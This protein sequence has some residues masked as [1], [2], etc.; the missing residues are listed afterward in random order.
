MQTI[1]ELK[2]WRVAAPDGCA[3]ANRDGGH[4]PYF[5][6]TLV[7]AKD[8]QDRISLAEIPGI[9]G[10]DELIHSPR[11][12]TAVIGRSFNCVRLWTNSTGL[13]AATKAVTA[14]TKLGMQS[15]DAT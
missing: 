14:A 12:Q 8:N 4:E 3:L 9:L 13:S 15:W 10:M 5:R 1:K 7:V 2:A 11:V 6:R